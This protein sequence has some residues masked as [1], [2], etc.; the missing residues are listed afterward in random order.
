MGGSLL[1]ARRRRAARERGGRA[2]RDH[3][4]RRSA[5]EESGASAPTAKLI[6]PDQSYLA[7]VNVDDG[8]ANS[9][10]PL[11]LLLIHLMCGLFGALLV[12]K[13]RSV[14]LLKTVQRA[15]DTAVRP[16]WMDAPS[17]GVNTLVVAVLVA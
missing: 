17:E 7:T 2:G 12:G 8:A 4:H 3:L 14:D 10:R 9:G 15:A 16:D 13:G 1:D 5:A 6:S 11:P